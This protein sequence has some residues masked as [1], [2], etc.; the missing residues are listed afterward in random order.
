MR[1]RAD[2]RFRGTR[3]GLVLSDEKPMA[4]RL[5]LAHP[6]SASVS[7]VSEQATL[8]CPV[9]GVAN[10]PDATVCDACGYSLTDSRTEK[11]DA[12]LDDLL[13]LRNVP[14]SEAPASIEEEGPDIDE[15]VAEQ[16]FDSLLVEIQPSASDDAPEVRAES[17]VADVPGASQVFGDVDRIPVLATPAETEGRKLL[18]ISGR[19]FDL[20]TFGSVGA[21]LAVFF[22]ARMFERPFDAANPLPTVL[23]AAVAI[24]GIAAAFLLYHLSNSAVAQGDRLV[25]E[26]RHQEALVHYERAIRMVRRPSYAWTS[27]GVAM[28]YLGRLDDAL[29][30]HETAIRLDPENE[31]AWCNL[32]TAYFKKAELEKALECYDRAIEIRPRYAIAWNNKGVVLARMNRFEEADSCHA[33]ATKLRPEYVAAW[34]NRGEVLARLGSREE[35]QKC[36]ERARAISR[37][38]SA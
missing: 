18:G 38:T 6:S 17:S 24:G 15:S 26:G 4:I 1:S 21:L 2:N 31:V 28:K 8:S 7:T 10:P 3:A 33:K 13:D 9:C 19:M 11:V 25:K 12:L 35:A 5:S 20:V 30:C 16:L 32:G 14:T 29:R 27:R 34:L 37:T 23:F 22:L 36:L